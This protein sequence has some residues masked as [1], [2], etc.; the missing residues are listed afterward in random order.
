[1]KKIL[2]LMLALILCVSVF[3]ACDSGKNPPEETTA[4]GENG[5]TAEQALANATAYVKNM[6]KGW[7][8][9]NETATD[10]E[11]VSSVKV[12]GVDYSVT[13]TVDN[14]AV[15]VEASDG[16]V[17]IN[18]DEES[19]TDVEYNLTA[20]V[21]AADGTKG[22][23]LTFKL[24][25]PG[26]NLVSIPDALKAEDGTFVTVKGTVTLINTPWDDGYKNIS[27]T[28]SDAEGNK[29]YV[30][31]L[32]TQVELGDIITV[33][34]EMATYNGARQIAQGATAEITGHEEI[35][36]EYPEKTIPEV[37]ATEDGE[38]VTVKGTV[39]LINT[40]W[41]ESNKNI[42]V[43]IV[44]KEGNELYIYRLSTKVEQGDVITVKGVVGSYNGSK[45]IAQGA[46]AEIT[47]H[48]EIKLEYV[49]KTIPDVLA[50]EDGALVTVKGTVK[51]IDTEWSDSFNNISVTIVDADGNELYIYRLSTKVVLGDKI[52][53]KGVVDTY[54]EAKQIAEGSTAEITG[55]DDSFKEEETSAETTTEAGET[56]AETTTEAGETTAETT[57][58]SGE[59][60]VE[61]TTETTEETT[62][63]EGKEETLVASLD[64]MGTT[65]LT[66]RTADQATYSAN[67]VTYVNDKASSTNPCFDQTGTYA[68]R[69]Y[70]GSTITVSYNTAF[71]KIVFTLDDFQSG[72]YLT[73]FDDMT[74]D[75]AT[76]TRDNDVVTITFNSAVTTFTTG[77]LNAQVRIE[78]IDLYN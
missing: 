67:G 37:L 23:A 24:K 65:N 48:E 8:T 45:Q 10:F 66:N 61:T 11:V 38:L 55:H 4:G 20:V 22:E 74:I 34:G 13:W 41:N 36:L 51:S 75:G 69:A 2:C 70:K 63:D 33:K 31:R 9:N 39:K 42:S 32:G 16:K 44:D 56:T 1:M 30:Y 29:L 12:A 28:I 76:I 40:P 54:N 46:T 77:N 21:S 53:V 47:G 25:V 50:S 17:V 78:K 52:T 57:T 60:T 7:Y 5:I 3:A 62:T 15:K 58:E 43:T 6:Y 68:A 18:V 72:K 73:G 64:M 49:E 35:K 19:E 59:T 27:V 26:A 71:K 14:E